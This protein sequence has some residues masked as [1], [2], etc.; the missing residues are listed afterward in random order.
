[1]WPPS[2]FLI[3]APLLCPCI[4]LADAGEALRPFSYATAA[5]EDHAAP[6]LNDAPIPFGQEGHNSITTG[7]GLGVGGVNAD[8]AYNGFVS[9]DT[10]LVDRFQAS[11][12]FGGFFFDQDADDA[13]AGAV[14]LM[15]RWHFIQQD[16]WSMFADAGAGLMLGTAKV[17][18]GGSEFN[19]SVRAGLGFTSRLG[20]SPNRLI[21][22]VR[23]QHYSNA[24]TA[25]AD[26][27]PGTDMPVFYLGVSFP[28]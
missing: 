11:L 4:A 3:C 15:F 2:R 1:M 20:D 26:D 18:R 9:L 27:N 19:F 21:G 7:F 23:W 5:E 16:S 12:E 25:G 14:N 28:L 24:R 6:E 8:F 22:G 13:I 10:F 17:P